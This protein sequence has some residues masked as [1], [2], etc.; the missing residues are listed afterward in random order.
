MSFLAKRSVGL[1]AGG[2]AMAAALAWLEAGDGISCKQSMPLKGDNNNKQQ[3]E[4]RSTKESYRQQE[5]ADHNDDNDKIIIQ[6]EQTSILDSG[7]GGDGHSCVTKLMIP[8]QLTKQIPT[9]MVDREE[10]SYE[11][12]SSTESSPLSS[13][14]SGD[15]EEDIVT[16]QCTQTL[17]K[18]QQAA[19]NLTKVCGDDESRKATSTTKKLDGVLKLDTE[20]A[21]FSWSD[22]VEMTAI[23]KLS[24]PIQN[25]NA[26]NHNN[27][28]NLST[29]SEQSATTVQQQIGNIVTNDTA[30]KPAD[31]PSARSEVCRF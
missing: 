19:V 11:I 26:A 8:E 1:L 23:N 25:S 7:G 18:A 31:S 30:Y 15:V 12:N 16:E 27:A 22:E 4:A 17:A 5:V 6:K 21:P 24:S 10:E 29:I 13:E 28:N 2:L 3:Q 20:E 14:H 9:S